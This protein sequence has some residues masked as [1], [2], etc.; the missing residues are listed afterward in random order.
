[1]ARP[2]TR[3]NYSG[4][5]LPIIGSMGEKYELFVRDSISLEDAQLLLHL[6]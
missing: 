6:D 5:F 2:T 4:G 3:R 1:M